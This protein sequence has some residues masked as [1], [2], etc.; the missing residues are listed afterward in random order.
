MFKT[1]SFNGY[2]QFNSGKGWEF[3]HRAA[4]EN[5][6]GGSIFDGHQVHHIDGNKTNNQH[7]NLTVLSAA[8]HYKIHHK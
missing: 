5:K 7:S 4:A 8:D 2:Q 6:L 1:R 3:S